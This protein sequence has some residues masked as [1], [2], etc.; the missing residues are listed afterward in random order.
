MTTEKWRSLSD[1]DRAEFQGWIQDTVLD[2]EARGRQ[3][4]PEAIFFGDP[5]THLAEELIDGLFYTFYAQRQMDEA[6]SDR[7]PLYM[8]KLGNLLQKLV[9]SLQSGIMMKEDTI[10]LDGITFKITGSRLDK[11]ERPFEFKITIK[12]KA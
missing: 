7:P 11:G 12:E 3:S 9:W 4:Y 6:L 2:A 5:L 1:R 10:D 8:S